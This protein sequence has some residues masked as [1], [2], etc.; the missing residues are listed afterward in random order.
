MKLLVLMV[1]LA[2]FVAAC[3]VPAEKRCATDTDC[4]PTPCCHPN[5][6]VNKESAPDCGGLLCTAEC[7]P[8]T[9]DCG[10]GEV[11]CLQGAC[12]A[13]IKP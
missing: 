10:Q 8:D 12:T 13:L 1:G 3:S 4:L 6:A 5:D 7:V 11:K 2:L 9:L